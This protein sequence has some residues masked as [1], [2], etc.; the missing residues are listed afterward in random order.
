MSGR[1]KRNRNQGRSPSP[2]ET[3]S[4]TPSPDSSRRE[5]GAS[6]VIGSRRWPVLVWQASAFG[7]VLGV[8][9]VLLSLLSVL[10]LSWLRE[11]ER[12]IA[13]QSDSRWRTCFAG[14]SG[15]LE[16]GPDGLC[17]GAG[18]FSEHGESRG[19]CFSGRRSRAPGAANQGRP[20]CPGAYHRV[21]RLP[22]TILWKIRP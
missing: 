21:V 4:G 11:R 1:K 9:A 22:M 3:G 2:P 7:L 12:S 15:W 14:S 16:R 17:R 18:S 5:A 20:E 6:T 10:E 13:S 8:A 19:R